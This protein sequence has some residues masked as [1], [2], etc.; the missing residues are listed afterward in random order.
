MTFQTGLTYVPLSLAPPC[1]GAGLDGN[2]E[3]EVRGW[4]RARNS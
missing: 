1:G 4:R 2:R 3:E